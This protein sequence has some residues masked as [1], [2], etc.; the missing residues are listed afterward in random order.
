MLSVMRHVGQ[1]VC[2]SSHDCKQMLHENKT[3]FI[4][5]ANLMHKLLNFTSAATELHVIRALN[6]IVC[7]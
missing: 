1:D 5:R 3:L 6:I 4:K 2:C 7:F